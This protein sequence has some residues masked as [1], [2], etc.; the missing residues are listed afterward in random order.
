MM[1]FDW[2]IKTQ[3]NVTFKLSTCQTKVTFDKTAE[4]DEDLMSPEAREI[5]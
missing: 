3:L 1:C 2:H 4:I 5:F